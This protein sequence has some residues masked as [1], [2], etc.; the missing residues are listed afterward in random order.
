MSIQSNNCNCP[1]TVPPRPIHRTGSTPPHLTIGRVP[2]HPIAHARL[3][4]FLLGIAASPR[5]PHFP[6]KTTVRVLAVSLMPG[7]HAKA[8]FPPRRLHTA[9]V[10]VPLLFPRGCVG[11]GWWG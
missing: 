11:R 3:L 10:R 2:I 7:A 5:D 4:L 1:G 6:T 9:Y 8:V